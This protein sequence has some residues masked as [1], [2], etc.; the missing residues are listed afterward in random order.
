MG[1]LDECQRIY[2]SKSKAEELVEICKQV[3][4]DKSL[5]GE[6]L[7]PTSGFFFGSDEIDEWYL[8]D[9]E[10]TIQIFSKLLSDPELAESIYYQ[11]SW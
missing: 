11:A 3:I 8:D 5:A 2:V 6:L 1:G 10:R 9:L 4:A 7:A